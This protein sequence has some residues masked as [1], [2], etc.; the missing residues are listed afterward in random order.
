MIV[1]L[2]DGQILR[3]TIRN[4]TGYVAKRIE[5]EA[6]DC[7]IVLG[8]IQ[9]GASDQLNPIFAQLQARF[10]Q[11]RGPKLYEHQKAVADAML[12]PDYRVTWRP[13]KR[14]ELAMGYQG[15]P[16]AMGRGD[17]YRQVAEEIRWKP[18]LRKL[19]LWRR[20]LSW[21]TAPFNLF[22]R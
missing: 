15:K 19:T 22:N 11:S 5:L 17:L 2:M 10:P 13:S 8:M 21:L 14:P 9:T 18:M 20:V 3:T 16:D 6:I 12:S 4:C 1:T 7:E